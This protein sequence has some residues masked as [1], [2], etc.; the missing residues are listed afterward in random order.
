MTSIHDR[1]PTQ[2]SEL[3][4]IEILT[5]NLRPEIRQELLYIP[6]NS[7]AHLR[8]LV[9]MRENFLNDDYVRIQLSNR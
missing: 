2:M 6:V 1:L 8:K 9:H 7:L 3:E 4:L 5:R